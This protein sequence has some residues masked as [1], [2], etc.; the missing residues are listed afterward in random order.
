MAYQYTNTRGVTYYLHRGTVTLAGSDVARPNYYFRKEP[1][2]NAIDAVPEGYE[3]FEGPR[4]ALPVLRKKG[5][6]AP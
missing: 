6:T 5:T 2:E 3:I 1:D 4:S